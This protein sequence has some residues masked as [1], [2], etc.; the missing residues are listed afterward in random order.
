M[1]KRKQQMW[2]RMISEA[3]PDNRESMF[4]TLRMAAWEAHREAMDALELYARLSEQYGDYHDDAAD[5]ATA[6]REGRE[7]AHRYDD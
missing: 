1:H 6:A 2:E 7:F 4:R 3:D 5:A